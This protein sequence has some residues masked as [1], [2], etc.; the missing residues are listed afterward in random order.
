M[1]AAK[2]TFDDGNN[3]RQKGILKDGGSG[4]PGDGSGETQLR[5]IKLDDNRSMNFKSED[6][7]NDEF[8]QQPDGR[9]LIDSANSEHQHPATQHGRNV[10]EGSAE[11]VTGSP[12]GRYDTHS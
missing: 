3:S 1:G 6:R 5:P 10:R 7:R 9:L 12:K 4:G 2:S 11:L 8:R